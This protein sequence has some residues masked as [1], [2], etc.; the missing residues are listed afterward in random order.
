MVNNMGGIVLKTLEDM[1][2]SAGYD[3]GLTPAKNLSLVLDDLQRSRHLLSE[4]GFV[5]SD[6]VEVSQCLCAALNRLAQ[7][8]RERVSSVP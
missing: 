8:E 2:V 7:L 4:A 5:S 3:P 6:G 1:L